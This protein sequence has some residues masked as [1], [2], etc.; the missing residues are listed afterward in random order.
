MIQ[1][2]RMTA[3]GTAV[4]LAGAGLAGCGSGGGSTTVSVFPACLTP[5]EPVALA[6]GARSNSPE[7]SLSAGV[8]ATMNSALGAHQAITIVRLDG[9]PQGCSTRRSTRRVQTPR[10]PRLI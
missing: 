2:L 4:L 9:S 10:W 3:A 1:I 6:I 8:T 5:K 7:P